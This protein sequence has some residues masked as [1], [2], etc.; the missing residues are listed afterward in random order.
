MMF[1]ILISK[2]KKFKSFS[3][4]STISFV[5]VQDFVAAISILIVRYM[6]LKG[7]IVES[8]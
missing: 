1:R 7:A 5:L 2:V 8:V 4:V 3:K 6:G